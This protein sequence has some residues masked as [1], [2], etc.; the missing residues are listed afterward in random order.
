MKAFLP[1]RRNDSDSAKIEL[2]LGKKTAPAHCHL[3]SA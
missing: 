1:Y 2:H 3:D